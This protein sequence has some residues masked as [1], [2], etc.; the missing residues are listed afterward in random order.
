MPALAYAQ[1]VQ[2]RAAR[3]EFDWEN[4]EGALDKVSEELVELETAES[5]AERESEFGDLLFSVVNAARWMGVDAEGALRKAN[6]RFCRRFGTMESLSRE[7]GLSFVRSASRAE[8]AVVGRGEVV[9][10][11]RLLVCSS[12]TRAVRFAGC[13]TSPHRPICGSARVPTRRDSGG[14]LGVPPR[15]PSRAGG[16]DRDIGVP[17]EGYARRKAASSR[18][19][20]L[21]SAN[22]GCYRA[23][24]TVG[25][26]EVC[27]KDPCR[28]AQ[29][30]YLSDPSQSR[31]SIS[32]ATE[33]TMESAS[34]PKSRSLR[35]RRGLT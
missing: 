6:G 13:F 2:E 23:Q 15:N 5:E 35:P 28:R 20:G 30:C 18:N 21:N 3:V 4:L 1:E 7:R 32:S 16:W 10:G 27:S 25:A 19:Q 14:G 8:R 26:K 31:R 24:C 17:T 22:A 34:G 29:P 11:L 12:P 9:R 33:L